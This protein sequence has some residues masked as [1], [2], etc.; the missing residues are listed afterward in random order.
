MINPHL[1]INMLLR[2]KKEMTFVLPWVNGEF[3]NK[4]W[5]ALVGKDG[6]R[7]AWLHDLVRHYYL[8]SSIFKKIC[9]KLFMPCSIIILF[10]DLFC[11]FDCV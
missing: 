11:W 4:F 5:A 6:N 3:Y 7:R 8:L 9:L 10:G 1:E 2:T